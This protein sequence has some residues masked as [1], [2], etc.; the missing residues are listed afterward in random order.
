MKFFIKSF[1][2]KCD[3]IR[4]FLRI[5]SHLLKKSLMKNFIFCVV[6]GSYFS[7]FWVNMGIYLLCNSPYSVQLREKDCT[8]KKPQIWILFAQRPG[9][10]LWFR[11]SFPWCSMIKSFCLNINNKYLFFL[12][13]SIF[14][15]AH[16]RGV[17]RCSQPPFRKK[18]PFWKKKIK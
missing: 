16:R 14:S 17:D 7:T 6:F 13:T 8:R 18:C 15:G 3:R 10:F 4:S 5:W 1:F 9:S 2:S 11:R 12:L